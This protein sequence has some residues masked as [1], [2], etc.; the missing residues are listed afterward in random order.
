MLFAT[1]NPVPQSVCEVPPPPL[2]PSPQLQAGHR[3]SSGE[4]HV[5]SRMAH[6]A[7]QVFCAVIYRHALA[8]H[9]LPLPQ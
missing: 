2:T 8:Q 4:C 7:Q 1:L 5:W 6:G 3:P 9:I